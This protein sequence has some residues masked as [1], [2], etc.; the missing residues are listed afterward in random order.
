MTHDDILNSYC[1][2]DHTP[3]LKAPFLIAAFSGWSNAGSVATDALE[4]LTEILAPTA[5]LSLDNEPFTHY[6][7]DRPLGHVQEGLL[8]DLESMVTTVRYWRNPHG[9][10]DLVLMLGREP[11]LNWETYAGL[12]LEVMKPLQVRRLYTLGGVQDTISHS[13][14]PQVSVVAS[15]PSLIAEAVEIESG[16]RAADYYGPVS[17][18]SRLIKTC[19]ENGIEGISL[20]G[21]VPA[22]LQRNPRLVAKL[23]TILNYAASMECPVGGLMQKA[24][25]L[26]RKIRDALAQ[27]PNLREFV[28]SL[29]SRES[30]ESPPRG[31]DKVI[32]LNEFL[33][34]DTTKDPET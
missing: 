8:R 23:V 11:H 3:E 16:I 6:A 24:I 10:H 5:F 19:V 12:V 30:A 31:D 25:E 33:K 21:H 18:H 29:E 32:R 14:P 20:W 34:R 9:N 7:M 1:R 13:A 17:I 26:D 15:S 22:Y 28:Q 2:W 4:Y 27:D